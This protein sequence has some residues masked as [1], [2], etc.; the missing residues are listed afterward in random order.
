MTYDIIISPTF[1]KNAKAI[2]KKDP[3]L[4]TR[5]QKTVS[6]GLGL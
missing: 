2:L 3:A 4:S 1:E 5:I 6:V